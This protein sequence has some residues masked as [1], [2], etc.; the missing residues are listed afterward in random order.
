MN[1]E[2]NRNTQPPRVTTQAQPEKPRRKKK[3]PPI[4]FNALD[5][6]DHKLIRSIAT[7]GA[8]VAGR[9]QKRHEGQLKA[10]K[11]TLG[12]IFANADVA[13]PRF[14][15]VLF[16]GLLVNATTANAKKI[17]SH[18]MCPSELARTYKPEA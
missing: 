12:E 13:D 8:R 3:A 5:E 15:E 7:T 9:Q 18:A 2:T 17:A 11:D 4:D 6:N 14:I 16:E 10:M 1:E